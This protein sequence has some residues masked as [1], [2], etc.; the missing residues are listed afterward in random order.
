MS[1]KVFSDRPETAK[2]VTFELDFWDGTRSER[3]AF[4]A[5]PV[6]DA[7]GLAEVNRL[8]ARAATSMDAVLKIKNHIRTM[9]ADDDGTPAEWEPTQ[10]PP[11]AYVPAAD[12]VTW[13]M[14]HET[15]PEVGIVGALDDPDP[16]P[17][18]LAP[19]GT[20]HPFRDAE[21]FLAAEAGS[22]RRR[23]V[24]L[25][26]GDNNLTVEYKT[27]MKLWQWLVSQAADRPTV[28]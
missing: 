5:F 28:R 23:W 26:D 2:S 10:L 11:T 3:H 21:K 1:D 22:S 16:E 17:Q 24:H 19:D 25:I 27:V 9:L 4:K 20:V 7:I 14:D 13:P 8:A 18:F 12:L 6:L 15:E